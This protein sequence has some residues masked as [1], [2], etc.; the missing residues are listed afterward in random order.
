MANTKIRLIS[1][2]E[3]GINENGYP[4]RKETVREVWAEAKGL[5]RSEFYAAQAAGVKVSGVFSLF[6]GLYRGEELLEHQGNR[7]LVLRAYPK[8][9]TEIELTC[10][11]EK[12]D[13][14]EV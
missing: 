3:T 2:T 12:V 7:Y 6:R 5:T 14:G 10:T 1:V 8:S 13:H 9:L 4:I 11:S